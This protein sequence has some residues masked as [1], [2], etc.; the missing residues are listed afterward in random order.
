MIQLILA[1][2]LFIGWHF[3]ASSPGP[4]A[5]LVARLGEQRFSAVYSAVAGLSLAWMIFAYA[6]ADYIELWE[7]IGWTRL[8]LVLVMPVPVF[9]LVCGLTQKNPTLVGRGFDKSG[10]PAPGVLKITRHPLMWAIGLWALAHILPN[11]EV[12]S[13]IFFGSIAVLAL[14]GTTRIDARRQARDPEGF[15]RFAAATSNL[16]LLALIENR[17]HLTFADIGWERIAG[18]A[19]LYV[20]LW[21]LHPWIAGVTIY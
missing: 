18:S 16:P 15:A 9:L 20:A 1:A 21:L 19:V 13:L 17:A 12:H 10:D 2:A 7:D 6:G 14:Y 5:A 8:V 3:V 11:G 4:R